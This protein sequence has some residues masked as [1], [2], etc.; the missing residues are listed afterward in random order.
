LRTSHKF[1][2]LLSLPLIFAATLLNSSVS[3]PALSTSGV[4]FILV[5]ILHPYLSCAHNT[6]HA[7]S[8]S[9]P[10]QVL[11]SI[12]VPFLTKSDLYIQG[13]DENLISIENKPIFPQS[14]IS[15]SDRQVF[16]PQALVQIIRFVTAS[17]PAFPG[18]LSMVLGSLLKQLLQLEPADLIQ[19]DLIDSTCSLCQVINF[20]L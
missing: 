17:T 14:L 15:T 16:V 10:L 12:P 20:D 11:L 19:F 2:N 4:V 18:T 5:V 1:I 6:C 7:K 13:C 9:D 8:L 3:S